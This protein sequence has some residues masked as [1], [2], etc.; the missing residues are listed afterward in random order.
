MN[1]TDEAVGQA[2]MWTSSMRHGTSAMI[3]LVDRGLV[4]H[5]GM[6]HC[7]PDQIQSCSRI[8]QVDCMQLELSP[9]FSEEL[10][11]IEWCARNGVGV[12]TYGALAYGLLARRLDPDLALSPEMVHDAA[13]GGWLA[14]MFT[15]PHLDR[16]IALAS[17]LRLLAQDLSLSVAQLLLTWNLAKEGVVCSLVGSLNASHI[18]EDAGASDV[19][20]TDETVAKIDALVA[21]PPS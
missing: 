10:P 4:R 3:E 6:S 17:F 18:I 21:L 2:R 9:L 8:R 11:I 14:E 12:I 13:V 7:L 20:L 19:H 15:Q 5:I 16:L 1:R